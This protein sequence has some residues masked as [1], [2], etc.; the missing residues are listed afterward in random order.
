[1]SKLHFTTAVG[2]RHK[3]EVT[4]TDGVHLAVKVHAV[5]IAAGPDRNIHLSQYMDK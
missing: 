2:I 5:S 4:D 3:V 1:M